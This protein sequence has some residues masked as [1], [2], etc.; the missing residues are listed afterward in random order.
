MY[1]VRKLFTPTDKISISEYASSHPI[2][3]KSQFYR[4]HISTVKNQKDLK[5]F[6]WG[7]L[8]TD[9]YSLTRRSSI[10]NKGNIS[11]APNWFKIPQLVILD[12][13]QPYQHMNCKHA[14]QHPLRKCISVSSSSG[15]L[16]LCQI[17]T[18][19]Q[20]DIPDQRIM[21]CDWLPASWAT[22]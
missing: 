11:S 15:R 7:L 20:R 6:S 3:M 13:P 19:N 22:S 4:S 10:N 18:I 12:Y 5:N 21:Q 14:W 8:T 17:K 1:F 9:F 2:K 16:T